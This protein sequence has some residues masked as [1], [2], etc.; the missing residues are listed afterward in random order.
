M[1]RQILTVLIAASL[2]GCT[3]NAVNQSRPDGLADSDVYYATE[4]AIGQCSS[5]GKAESALAGA[6]LSSVI[7][8]GVKQAVD[9]FGKALKAAGDER[10]EKV[11][12]QRNAEFSRSTVPAG[13]CVQ[14]VRGWIHRGTRGPVSAA[15]AAAGSWEDGEGIIP[16][17]IATNLYERSGLRLAARPDFFFEGLL[18]RSSDGGLAA[19]TP[20]YAWLDDPLVTE[21]LNPTRTR[22]LTLSLAVQPVDGKAGPSVTLSGGGA[23]VDLGRLESRRGRCYQPVPTIVTPGSVTF[24]SGDPKYKELEEA[25]Q[26]LGYASFGGNFCPH[27]TAPASSGDTTA[28]APSA[29]GTLGDGDESEDDAVA[30]SAMS[31]SVPASVDK[32]L[33]N[34]ILLHPPRQSEYF[35]FPIA[36]D[37]RP[38]TLRALVT[39]VREANA[40]LQFLTAV[41][42]DGVDDQVA[43]TLTGLIDPELRAQRAQEAATAR[44][45]AQTAADDALVAAIGDVAACVTGPTAATANKARKS[46]RALNNAYRG[47]GVAAPI[48]EAL[49]NAVPISA[50]TTEIARRCSAAEDALTAVASVR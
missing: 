37:V 16:A 39:E 45:A 4:V 8:A 1:S 30:V 38:Y 24:D 27:D 32:A 15:T 28:P 10:V 20:L 2:A 34:A 44:V 41:F 5:I 23:T 43:N 26:A 14:V 22:F 49:I 13:S 9:R 11:L 42:D 25:A 33:A 50:D 7:A 31:P 21:L 35:S 40:A 18:T 47:V 48:A 36:A 17:D 3:S 46:L 29:R 12:T 19:I 6:L